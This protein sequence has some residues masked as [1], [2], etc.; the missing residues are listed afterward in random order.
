[1]RVCVCEDKYS[2]LL[3][4]EDEFGGSNI[5]LCL[6][7]LLRAQVD[8]ASASRGCPA[9][10]LSRACPWGSPSIVKADAEF[11]LNGHGAFKAFHYPH[12]IGV[13]FAYWH[14]INQ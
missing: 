12:N 6:H 14:E 7:R 5:V 2:L 10:S 8:N 11:Y 9:I 1:M 13:S 3:L 4:G